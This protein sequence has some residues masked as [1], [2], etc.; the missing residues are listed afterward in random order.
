MPKAKILEHHGSRA[1]R[2]ANPARAIAWIIR[3]RYATEVSRFLRPAG[4]G[5]SGKSGRDGQIRTADLS[6]RR[7]PLY[8]SELRPHSFLLYPH[9]VRSVIRPSRMWTV[10]SP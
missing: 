3:R 4:R 6:L 9:Y 7:R 2:I 1:C 5:G 10:E 8:P